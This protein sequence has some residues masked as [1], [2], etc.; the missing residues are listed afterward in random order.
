MAI[1]TEENHEK[2]QNNRTICSQ[3]SLTFDK[4]LNWQLVLKKTTRNSIIIEENLLR[5][6]SQSVRPSRLITSAP[7]VNIIMTFL[8]GTLCENLSM[9][10][11][12]ILSGHPWAP[13]EILNA[14]SCLFPHVLTD[15]ESVSGRSIIYCLITIYIN[16]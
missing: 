4:V 3:C 10:L 15:S 12:L 11:R 2:H 16:E 9:K 7:Y 5:K 6:F 1:G 8:L 13:L 14:L